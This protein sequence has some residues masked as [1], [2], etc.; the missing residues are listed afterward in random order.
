MSYSKEKIRG[1]LLSELGSTPER[2]D[3]YQSNLKQLL[4]DSLGVQDDPSCSSK[5]K[6]DK[7][8]KYVVDTSKNICDQQRVDK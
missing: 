6:T 5:T 3:T 2:Y 1:M 7:I 8:Q 4:L